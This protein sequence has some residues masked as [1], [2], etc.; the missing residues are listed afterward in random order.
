MEQQCVALTVKPCPLNFETLPAPRSVYTQDESV[1]SS[2]YFHLF[3]RADE[4]G[5]LFFHML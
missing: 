1:L 4:M 3:Y 2:F 5:Y